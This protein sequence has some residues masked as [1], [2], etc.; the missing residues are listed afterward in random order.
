LK[1]TDILIAGCGPVGV[2]AA[3]AASQAGFSVT[4]LEAANEIDTS[5]RAATTH[6]STLDMIERVGLIDRFKAEGLTARH[7]DFR[8]RESKE[9]IARFDHALLEGETRHPY[10]VQTE[11]HKLARMGV[12]ALRLRDGVE[13][14]FGRRV[15]SLAQDEHAVT[16]TAEGAD[17]PEAFKARW[18]IGADGGRST[19]RK[20]LN[21]EFEGMTWP[22]KF[23]VLTV[24]DDFEQILG[25]SLRNYL[26]DPDEWVNLFKVSGDDGKG[27]WRAVFPSRADESDEA[28]LDRQ[29]AE[30]RLQRL[31]ENPQPYQLVHTNVYRVH[32]RVARQF[33]S[34]RVFLAG[35]SAHVNNPIGGL[36]LNCGIHDAMELV[37]TLVEVD[38]QGAGASL[39]DRYERRRRQMNIEFVQQQ[40]ITNKKRLEQKD[41]AQRKLALDELRA[42]SEE[43]ARHKAFLLRSSL[44]ESV[45]QSKRI[46]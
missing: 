13:V 28:A 6:P 27:R 45:R 23:I 40:T 36:G 9:L 30:A 24:L 22:E 33:R 16:V 38:R 7:F 21:I 5:P 8:D 32:Q 1:D 20:A 34:G 44:I 18:V 19:V 29:S 4:L 17:G 26:A 41:P 43:P 46:D 10:V 11:Q 37:D 35:D 2:V 3:L 31:C 14:H 12:E 25:A 39:L 15:E 42:I